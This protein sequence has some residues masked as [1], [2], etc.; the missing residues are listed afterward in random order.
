MLNAGDEVNLKRLTNC[1]MQAAVGKETFAIITTVSSNWQL[2][3]CHQSGTYQG[4]R[5]RFHE[6][7]P[8]R[9]VLRASLCSGRRSISTVLS[10]DCLGRPGLRHQSAGVFA[11]QGCRPAELGSCP[12]MDLLG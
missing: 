7:P 9:S 1:S 4:R 8:C 12:G 10:H 6:S 11:V 2:T 5:C 3:H